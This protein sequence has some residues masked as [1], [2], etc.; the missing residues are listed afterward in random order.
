MNRRLIILAMFAW[1]ALSLMRLSCYAQDAASAPDLTEGDKFVPS[2][3]VSSPAGTLELRQQATVFGGDVK[4]KQVCRWS[5]EDAPVFTPIADLVI[6]HLSDK[7]AFR[8]ISVDDVRQTLHDAGINI[9][10][11][12]FAGATSC[13]ISRSDVPLDA[14][15]AMQQWIDAQKN[16]AEKSPGAAAPDPAQSSDIPAAP[17][18]PSAVPAAEVQAAPDPNFHSLRQL[19]TADICQR[20]DVS[21]LAIQMTWSPEDE[22]VL[23]LVEPCFKFDILPSRARALGTV[24]WDVNIFTDTA[25]KKVHIIATAR[26][27]EDEVI[28][29]KP[30]AVKE[31]LA[32]DD[33]TTRRILVDSLPGQTL[34]RLDQCVNQQAAEDLKPGMIMTAQLVDPVPLVKPGQLVTVTLTQGSIQIRSVARALEEGSLGQAIKVRYENTRDILDVTVTGPQEARLGSN[35]VSADAVSP[36]N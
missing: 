27:W 34:L 7:T 19:L 4:L 18:P 6:L 15:D 13:T 29:A 33:F 23:S 20:L 9:A 16:G 1:A 25:S 32:D 21:P 2:D 22:K 24:S 26:A 28:V 5:D 30:L 3:S 36:A 8:P 17:A 11:I 35:F 31:I 12:D 10:M 14:H